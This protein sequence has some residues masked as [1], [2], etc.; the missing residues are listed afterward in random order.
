M[1]SRQL[2]EPECPEDEQILLRLGDKALNYWTSP[3]GPA[4]YDW[5]AAQIAS[6]S[7]PV[8]SCVKC[9]GEQVGGAG[10]VQRHTTHR[11]CFPE[12]YE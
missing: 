6:W 7:V 1:M 3:R 5:R 4:R 12:A 10:L 8:A 2:P 11:G 9:R